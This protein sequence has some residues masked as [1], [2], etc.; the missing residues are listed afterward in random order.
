MNSLSPV[1]AAG[2]LR[3]LRSV[4]AIRA[5]GS[6]G[7]AAMALH[8]SQP[9][10]TRA[11]RSTEDELGIALFE[12]AARGMLPTPAGRLLAERAQ[13]AFAALA[14]ACAQAL[15]QALPDGC[16]ATAGARFA[17]L[18]GPQQLDS[19]VAVA[20]HGSGTLAGGRIGRSQPTI[21]HNLAELERLVGTP[22]FQRSRSGTALTAAGQQLLAGTRRAL[23]ELQQAGQEMRVFSGRVSGP[24]RVAALPLSSGFLL[25]QAIDRLLQRHPGLQLSVVDGSYEALVQQ[26]RC[27][28]VDLIVGALRLQEAPADL[29]EEALFT[30][31]M[32]VVARAGHPCLRGAP[33]DLAALRGYR[34]AV[35]LPR[36]PA[37]SLFEA[38]F[39][40]AGL[41]PPAASLQVNNP[42]LLRRFVLGG[43]C[44]ALASPLQ[45]AAELCSGQLVR[46]PVALQA[47]RSI[48]VTTRRGGG[49]APAVQAL[50]DE[51]R[52]LAP[53]L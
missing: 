26:L 3:G 45:V 23:A 36:T 25:P 8:L 20:E 16:A 9:A 47:S 10:V 14:Q 24:V 34:W 11:L 40:R 32:A 12:R 30:D 52:A 42:Q 48:G 22:L 35:P 38:V 21:H 13:S 29:A 43:D 4:L 18:V 44:L 1:P 49:L 37:R 2:N 31:H 41:A 17:A 5:H 27:A 28:E 19:L 50:L 53:A 39:Q 15:A 51:M 6:V 7:R 33:A 46:L